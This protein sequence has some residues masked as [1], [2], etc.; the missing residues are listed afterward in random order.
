MTQR[1]LKNLIIGGV[2]IG[3]LSISITVFGQQ[4]SA[5]RHPNL[6]EAQQFIEK[7]IDKLTAAQKA[8]DFDMSGHA[9]KAKDLLKQAYD[10]I[11]LAAEAANAKK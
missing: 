10:E 1:V 11:R 9:A 4:V 5:A 8:N 7:A 2:V 6:A 3:L